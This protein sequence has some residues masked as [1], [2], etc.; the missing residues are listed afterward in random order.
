MTSSKV[1]CIEVNII[2]FC[3]NGVK[4]CSFFLLV[5]KATHSSCFCAFL[6][7]LCTKTGYTKAEITKRF[8][9]KNFQQKGLHE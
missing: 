1:T 6:K 2:M 7:L 4:F 9:V 8:F 5:L 3:Q